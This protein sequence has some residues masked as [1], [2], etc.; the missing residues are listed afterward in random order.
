MTIPLD[1]P[2]V[3]RETENKVKFEER[4][5]QVERLILSVR[6]EHISWSSIQNYTMRFDTL[7]VPSLLRNRIRGINFKMINK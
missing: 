2:N 4:I 5:V 1:K 6:F 7:S 3:Q